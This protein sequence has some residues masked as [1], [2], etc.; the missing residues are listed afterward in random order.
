MGYQIEAGAGLTAPSSYIPT[1]TA[2]V[3]VT[4]YTLGAGGLITL[5]EVPVVDA[6][7]K[8]SGIAIHT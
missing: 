2:P 8:W 5:G 6:Q 1:T 3:T 7:L 4:D